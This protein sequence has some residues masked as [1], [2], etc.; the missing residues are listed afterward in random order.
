MDAQ[1]QEGRIGAAYTG[2][3]EE[4]RYQKEL[5]QQRALESAI[6]RGAGRSGVVD[7]S[8]AQITQAYAPQLGRLGEMQ[9]AELT[10]IANQLGL[11]QRQ[12]YDLMSQLEGQRGQLTATELARQ[13]ELGYQRDTDWSQDQ[14]KRHLEMLP[15]TDL[16]QAERLWGW[17]Q[18]SGLLPETVGY[19]GPGGWPETGAPGT[20]QQPQS[21][22]EGNITYK[23]VG[24]QIYKNG[25]LVPLE[26]YKYIPVQV[27][28]T[29]Q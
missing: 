28:G 24:G 7:W 15:Y 23:N 4:L 16:T 3:T 20:T 5:D 1:A 22:T 10:T 26:N 18:A 2:R 25:V 19:P 29:R 27:G 14:W 9:A 13:E 12:A 8:N 6:A 11:T 21:Y 17:V